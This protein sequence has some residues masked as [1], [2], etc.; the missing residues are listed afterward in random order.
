MQVTT[1]GLNTAVGQQAL[2]ANTS[3]TNSVAL[4]ALALYTATSSENTAVGYKALYNL[5]TGYQNVA[6]GRLAGDGITTG[7]NNSCIG[8]NSETSASTDSNQ[9]ILGNSSIEVIRCQVQSI[10]SLSDERDKTD[11]VD[12]PIGLNF[13]NK[14]RPVKFKWDIRDAVSDNPHQGRVRGGFIAQELKAAQE[15]S[16]VAFMDLVH[17]SNPDKMEAKQGNLIPVMVQ[18]IK[19]LSAENNALKARLDAAGL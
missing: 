8:Y 17:E 5:T 15:E 1:G 11:I 13:V 12:M 4:G 9:I 16:D 18:A 6:I 19:E 7:N 2:K 10:S 14:L 3:G